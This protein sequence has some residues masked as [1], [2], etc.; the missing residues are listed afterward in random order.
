MTPSRRHHFTPGEVLPIA[1]PS[2]LLNAIIDWEEDRLRAR[3][4]HAQPGLYSNPDG[5][6]PCWVG[7]EYMAQAVGALA[8]I[9]DLRAGRGP[10]PGVLL[11]TRR[12]RAHVRTFAAGAPV[13]VEVVEVLREAEGMG[14][15]DCTISGPALLAEASIKMMQVADL[16]TLL[17][18]DKSP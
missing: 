6:V 9:R 4:D 2:I 5:S 17:K 12:F 11:G 13:T 7:L 15:Y 14:A 10:R 3:V 1:G 18:E 16:A 8:G